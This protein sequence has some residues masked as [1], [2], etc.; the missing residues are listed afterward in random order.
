[1]PTHQPEGNRAGVFITHFCTPCNRWTAD[2]IRADRHQQKPTDA[3]G[4]GSAE[5][6]AFGFLLFCTKFWTKIPLA[7]PDKKAYTKREPRFLREQKPGL[8]R[9]G[10]RPCVRLPSL[11]PCFDPVSCGRY[12]VYYFIWLRK[13]VTA[14]VSARRTRR[15]RAFRA[16]LTPS[17]TRLRRADASARGQPCGSV[18]NPLLHAVQQVDG[19]RNQG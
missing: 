2:E 15:K 17:F 3:T 14:E 4:G 6:R 5:E 11:K 10:L 19:R 9:R 1:V 8:A 7:R 18:Y 12:G 13:P 16:W